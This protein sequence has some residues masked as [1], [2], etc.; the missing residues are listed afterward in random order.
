VKDIL[1]LDVTPLTLSIETLG[2]VAT[3]QIDRN[4]T[5]P[6]R[7]SQ[8]F[9]TASDSQNQVEIHVLQGER[10]M[11]VDN[12]SLGKFILD[13]IPSAPRGV[14]QIE[15]TFD[16]DANGILK[17]TAQDKASGRSQHITITAS[18]GLSEAEVENM[19]KEAEAH[20]DEDRKRKD[21][22]EPATRRI[23]WHGA[24]KALKDFGDKVPADLKS[25]IQAS[26]TEVHNKKAG[27]WMRSSRLL[28]AGQLIQ[29]SGECYQGQPETASAVSQNNRS[30]RTRSG[31]GGW[32]SEGM[33]GRDK[34]L[35]HDQ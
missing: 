13:G 7:R 26:V 31:C 19:R 9:S 8:V 35:N 29:R 10:P 3:P 16:I 32:C 30:F 34:I 2:S 27:Q 21:I 12:K 24:E 33:M 22:I 4:T 1:L 23:T 17:V 5:I 25:E 11:A 20:A 6:T 18:S 14:P 28:G 15:V